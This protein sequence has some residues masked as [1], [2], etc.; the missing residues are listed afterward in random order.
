MAQQY[1]FRAFAATANIASVTGVVAS[2]QF[3]TAVGGA[4]PVNGTQVRIYNPGTI[5]VFVQFGSTQTIAQT[6]LT[7]STGLPIA[8]G[9]VEVLSVDA[10]IA[11]I[12]AIASTTAGALYATIGE[13]L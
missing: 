10:S 4:G 11:W 9:A 6:G 12:A 8:P 13:G 2:V 3:V 5:A 1:P 7:V